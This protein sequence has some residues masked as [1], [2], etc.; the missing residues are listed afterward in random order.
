MP[1]SHPSP[2]R[3]PVAQRAALTRISQ[4]HQL[5]RVVRPGSSRRVTADSLAHEL[6]VSIGT[7]KLDLEAMRGEFGAPIAWDF[8]LRSYCYT[9]PFELRPLLWLDAVEVLSLMV[10]SRISAG[11]RAFPVG[12]ALASALEKIAPML[13]GAVSLHPNALDSVFSVP[14]DPATDAESRHFLLLRDAI[15]ARHEVRIVYRK[16][17]TPTAPETRL[18][19]PLRLVWVPDG[20]LLIAQD[21]ARGGR[22]NFDLSRIC[23]AQL[24]GAIFIWPPDFDAKKCLAGSLGRFIG[25]AEHQ[26]RI[27][28]AASFAP[29]V[30]ERPWHASQTLIERAG[31]TVE[32]TYR[33]NHLQDI[34]HRVL[35]CA[36]QAEV[37]APPELRQRIRTAATALGAKHG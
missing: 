36:G 30:R 21:P 34:E 5:I 15:E 2:S 12:R 1:K 31:G 13:G 16:P 22:R 10:A 28:F 29:Y 6:E 37:L 11:W 9:E 17:A 20:C 23:D 4:I 33:L 25:E 35:A 19:H 8:K 7:V 14:E 24:S 3:A 26:V 27:A 32:A 18:V